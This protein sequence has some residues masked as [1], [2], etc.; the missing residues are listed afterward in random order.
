[1]ILVTVGTQG[2]FDRLVQAVDR[3]AAASGRTDVLAQ[4]GPKAWKPAHIRWTEFMEPPAFRAAFEGA[5]LIVSH[6]GIGTLVAALEQGK[7]IVVM[8][9][10]ARLR[11]HRNDHQVATAAHF[12]SKHRV[13]VASEPD[14][15]PLALDEIVRMTSKEL[16]PAPRARLVASEDLLRSVRAFIDAGA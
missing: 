10:L 2:P 4:I 13:R 3:W 8:P 11:E 14:E 6:A 9:R 7:S 15:L 5:D 1:L 16:I 12:C